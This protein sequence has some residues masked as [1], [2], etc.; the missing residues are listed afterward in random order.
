[1]SDV[2]LAAARKLGGAAARLGHPVTAC[3]YNPGS[4]HAIERAAARAYVAA[5]LDARPSVAA[6]VNLDDD[7]QADEEGTR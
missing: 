3:P 2:M 7:D 6:A 5:Y 1:M 4:P